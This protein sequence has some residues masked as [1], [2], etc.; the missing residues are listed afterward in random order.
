MSVAADKDIKLNE[1]GFLEDLHKQTKPSELL[2]PQQVASVVPFFRLTADEDQE[3][4]YAPYGPVKSGLKVN[5]IGGATGA[6]KT[7]LIRMLAGG[8][9]TSPK[10]MADTKC[11]SVYIV[12]NEDDGKEYA[13]LDTAGLC[14]TAAVANKDEGLQQL[15][16]NAVAATIQTYEME[17]VRF[18]MCVDM[19][20]RLP[21]NFPEVWPTMQVALGGEQLASYCHFVVTKANGGSKTMIRRL[22]ELPETP[23]WRE[24][25]NSPLRWQVTS[26]GDENLEGIWGVM[27][28]LNTDVTGI[29]SKAV[30][31]D[32]ESIV[33]K[34]QKVEELQAEIERLKAS[35]P[36]VDLS[37]L[38]RKLDEKHRALGGLEQKLKSY[39]EDSTCPQK[40]EIRKMQAQVDRSNKELTQLKKDAA[41]GKVSL[42]QAEKELTLWQARLDREISEI[43]K[44]QSWG[45]VFKFFVGG[46]DSKGQQ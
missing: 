14:D 25:A 17:I 41:Y 27:V 15:L 28:P 39:M 9:M 12:K 37:Q 4:T 35:P 21:G 29:G 36:A 20:G 13:I 7:S 8:T 42:D 2:S 19:V 38:Q 23:F 24:L 46:G 30:D 22:K 18:M 31:P 3:L 1:F 11:P 33:T 32:A 26:C 44:M 6:G 5:V 10:M 16:I 45:M 40:A 43:K 34:E